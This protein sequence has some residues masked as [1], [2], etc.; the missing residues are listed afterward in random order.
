MPAPTGVLYISNAL[1]FS[2]L[3][4]SQETDAHL[5][6][7]FRSLLGATR[8][9][10]PGFPSCQ[11]G[12][13]FDLLEPF[14]RIGIC[15]FPEPSAYSPFGV[16]RTA[17]EAPQRPSTGGSP[18]PGPPSGVPSPSGQQE[19]YGSLPPSSNRSWD[20]IMPRLA[21][22]QT[23]RFQHSASNTGPRTS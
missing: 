21:P 5:A 13:R 18:G 2:T 22:L 9:S 12:S 7:N 6:L 17:R 19:P 8:L 11:I 1:A 3:L 14:R 15:G 10:Y 20:Q 23:L 4:S 16:V